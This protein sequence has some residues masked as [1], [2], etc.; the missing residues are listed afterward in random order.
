M[1]HYPH[2]LS[3]FFT[4]QNQI[5]IGTG[6]LLLAFLGVAF[7]FLSG[8]HQMLAIVSWNAQAHEAT[9]RLNAVDRK[10]LDETIKDKASALLLESLLDDVTKLDK[11]MGAEA[12]LHLAQFQSSL[13]NWHG[14]VAGETAGKLRAQVRELLQA[15]SQLVTQ[16]QAEAEQLNQRLVITSFALCGLIST[17]LLI[18]SGRL[19]RYITEPTQQMLVAMERV[20]LGEVAPKVAEGQANE[21]GQMARAFNE[22]AAKISERQAASRY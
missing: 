12:K 1:P 21:F 14:P 8:L 9:N 19:T 15:H 18:F 10:L 5:K 3:R 20:A 4:L 13:D 2:S 16:K 17:L 7:T 22:M 6:I 11:L